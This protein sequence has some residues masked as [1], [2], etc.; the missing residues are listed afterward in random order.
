MISSNFVCLTI[1]QHRVRSLSEKEAQ[2]LV[3]TRIAFATKVLRDGS[4]W[5]FKIPKDPNQS[6]QKISHSAVLKWECQLCGVRKPYFQDIYV[7]VRQVH[8]HQSSDAYNGIQIFFC[9]W[10][11][12]N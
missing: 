6:I 11:L 4:L 8:E 2:Q 7:H 5:N 1:I 3:L 9:G 10:S 12:V